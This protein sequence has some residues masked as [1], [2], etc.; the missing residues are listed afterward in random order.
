VA[1]P[2]ILHW[3]HLIE[4]G[5]PRSF[6]I[7][8]S[9]TQPGRQKNANAAKQHRMEDCGSAIRTL[10]AA[11][12]HL[13]LSYARFV[14]EWLPGAEPT[15]DINNSSNPSDPASVHRAIFFCFQLAIRSPS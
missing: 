8:A 7:I 9:D 13:E 14:D 5:E 12:R 10:P 4:Q 3:E 11:K 1:V 6:R 2:K 15:L